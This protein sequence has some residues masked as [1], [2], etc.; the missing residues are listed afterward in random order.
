MKRINV[1]DII[2]GRT[3]YRVQVGKI[4]EIRFYYLTDIKAWVNNL[5]IGYTR[6]QWQADM[7]LECPTGYNNS[8]NTV[9]ETLEEAKAVISSPEYQERLQEHFDFCDYLY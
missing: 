7:G 2:L 9:V 4:Y 1:K 8:L 5:E 3:Y 6:I